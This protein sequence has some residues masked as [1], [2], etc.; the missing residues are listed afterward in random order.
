MSFIRKFL[1]HLFPSIA[2][3]DFDQYESEYMSKPIPV[4]KTGKHDLDLKE[5]DFVKSGKDYLKDFFKDAYLMDSSNIEVTYRLGK[6]KCNQDAII[7]VVSYSGNYKIGARGNE[8][9]VYMEAK[10]D[11]GLSKSGADAVMI[12]FREL[13]YV[14]GDMIELVYCLGLD[15][16][17][18][19]A[20]V[21]GDGC[22]EAI[23]TLVHGVNSTEPAT[24]EENLFDDFDEAWQYIE[25]LLEKK[26]N[27]EH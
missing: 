21:L 16:D 5:V 19:V 13:N 7:L 9:A 6:A 15:T 22:R 4:K 23:G 12:D 25:E 26:E 20:C 11:L 17:F 3:R 27:S 18:P 24:T 8:D 10:R 1:R 2:R 14:W